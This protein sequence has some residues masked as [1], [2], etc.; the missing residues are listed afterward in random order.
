MKYQEYEN[1][2]KE[3]LLEYLQSG[4]SLVDA[5]LKDIPKE[6]IYEFDKKYP[7]D[8]KK[9]LIDKAHRAMRMKKDLP[10]GIRL[11]KVILKK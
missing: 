9:Q 10:E 2:L 5:A 1:I 6:Y 8:T 7:E 3:A 4:G 11:V